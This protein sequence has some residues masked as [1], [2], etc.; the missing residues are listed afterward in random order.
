MRTVGPKYGKLLN[1]IKETLAGINGVAAM[2][3]LNETGSLKFDIDG[4][5]VE[6]GREDL[7]IETVESDRYVSRSDGKVTVIL[8]KEM[9]PELIEEGFV[10]EII[11]KVQTM[12][13]EAG[14]EVMDQIG[15]YAEGNDTIAKIISD[16]EESIKGDVLAKT[17]TLGS[18]DG[19]VKEW[20]INSEKVTLGVKKID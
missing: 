19:Y 1:K 16:N 7:L 17:V 9:T 5:N 13:K 8:D 12:R 3:E 11:S 10:R 14:F 15:L 18:T 2:N 4:E 6:L 20:K